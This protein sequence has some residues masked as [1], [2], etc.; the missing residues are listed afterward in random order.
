MALRKVGPKAG[1]RFR[2]CPERTLGGEPRGRVAL[3]ASSPLT[4]TRDAVLSRRGDDA[5]AFDGHEGQPE[6][7]LVARKRAY[8]GTCL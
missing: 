1:D 3:S 6:G 7:G 8:F 4:L 2:D 5:S